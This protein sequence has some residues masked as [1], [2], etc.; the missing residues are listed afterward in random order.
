MN[1]WCLLA[2]AAAAVIVVVVVVVIVTILVLVTAAAALHFLHSLTGNILTT[3]NLGNSF[4]LRSQ[5]KTGEAGCSDPLDDLV[6]DKL[7]FP[8]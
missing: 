2:A 7:S 5:I 8:M 6:V 1:N 4:N 3:R